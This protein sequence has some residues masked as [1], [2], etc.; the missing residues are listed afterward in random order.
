MSKKK[1]KTVLVI[2]GIDPSGGAG[3]FIDGLAIRSAGQHMAA[4]PALNTVQDG[5]IFKTTSMYDINIFTDQLKIIANSNNIGAIK[6]GALGNS[7]KYINVLCNFIKDFLQGTPLIVDPVL[8][9]TS[10]GILTDQDA[11]DSIKNKLFP[12]STLVTPNLSEAS[13]L[14]GFTVDNLQ[15]MKKAAVEILKLGPSNVLIKGGHLKGET[16]YDVLATNSED[17]YV[18]SGRIVETSDVRGTGCALAS[19]IASYLAIQIPLKKAVEMARVKLADAMKNSYC[20]VE[21]TLV[22]GF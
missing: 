21:G 9:S 12:L 15:S 16:I 22:L 18:L 10:G 3:L 2:G 14:C 1:R 6:T 19:L 5:I 7:S 8:G 4:V 11:F 13:V 20:V 17:F